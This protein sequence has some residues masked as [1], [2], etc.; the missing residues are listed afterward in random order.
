MINPSKQGHFQD[1]ATQDLGW[2][3]MI[4]QHFFFSSSVCRRVHSTLEFIIYKLTDFPPRLNSRMY[5]GY[6]CASWYVT[7]I[8]LLAGSMLSVVLS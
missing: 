8:C 2:A 6:A 5:S 4:L 1:L 3:L 7:Y